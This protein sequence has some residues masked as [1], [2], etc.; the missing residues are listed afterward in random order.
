MAVKKI[1]EFTELLNIQDDDIFLVERD[2]AGYSVKASVLKQYIGAGGG[3]TPEDPDTN[4][5]TGQL[6]E[7]LVRAIHQERL[8]ASMISWRRME[9]KKKAVECFQFQAFLVR[10]RVR[11][12]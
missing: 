5:I 4:S 3:D 7:R 10:R 9:L 12:V 6:T 11:I 1:S 2:G 8:L